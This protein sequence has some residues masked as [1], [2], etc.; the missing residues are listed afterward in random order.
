[1]TISALLRLDALAKRFVSMCACLLPFKKYG[2]LLYLCN[3]KIH[4][5]LHSASEIMRWGSLINSSEEAEGTQKINVK[6]PGVNLKH[7]CTEGGTLL[8]HAR[9]KET[10]RMLGSAIQGI[11]SNVL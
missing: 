6:G 1:M 5:I 7:R 2:G 10:T 3:E 8:A 4:S 11:R 9:R